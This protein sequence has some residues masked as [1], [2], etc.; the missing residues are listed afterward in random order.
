MRKENGL[1]IFECDKDENGKEIPNFS[2]RNNQ[3]V[4][5]SVKAKPKAQYRTNWT[6][7]CNVTAMVMSLSYAGFTLPDG[8]YSQPEDNLGLFILTDKV[9]LDKWKNQAPAQYDLFIKSLD[10]KLTKE[11]VDRYLYFPTELHDYLSLGVNRWLGTTATKFTTSYSFKKMLE[12][13]MVF[14]NL[15]IVLSTTF[16]GFG[17]IVCCTGVAYKDGTVFSD[18]EEVPG[19]TPAGIY[20]DDPWGKYNPTTNK[21][22]APNG[23][24]DIFIPWD[25]VVKRVKP[26]NSENVKWMHLFYHGLAAV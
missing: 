18:K 15:P 14:G 16:G 25:V 20:V 13:E 24:N 2:Q 5:P 11:Q 8:P 17:H 22:D 1:I 9:L 26:A 7:M 4:W 6:N 19:P 10:G 12:L 23:G 21:Y 3:L